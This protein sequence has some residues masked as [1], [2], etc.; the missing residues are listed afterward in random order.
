M[1]ASGFDTQSRCIDHQVNCI[2]LHMSEADF[3]NSVWSAYLIVCHLQK[4]TTIFT[5]STSAYGRRPAAAFV[6]SAC[7]SR[8]HKRAVKSLRGQQCRQRRQ[9][10][11]LAASE[12]SVG[13]SWP[14]VCC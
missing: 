13:G 7:E 14:H 4:H 8:L 10:Q 2:L 1:N 5:H 12:V 9:L 3:A 6:T 11:T